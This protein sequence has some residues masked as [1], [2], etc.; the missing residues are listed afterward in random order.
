MKKEIEEYLKSMNFEFVEE[1]DEQDMNWHIVVSG[2]HT[3]LD[4]CVYPE[5]NSFIVYDLETLEDIFWREYTSSTELFK[6]IQNPPS[7]NQY[8]ITPKAD[9]E[10]VWVSEFDNVSSYEEL[11]LISHID[12]VEADSIKVSD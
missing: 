7:F 3:K 12:T 4:Y 9:T 8:A 11:F 2:K 5:T 1:S 10:K 6:A